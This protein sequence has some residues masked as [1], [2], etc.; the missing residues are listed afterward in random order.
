[1]VATDR[2]V[3]AGCMTPTEILAA[4]H[5]GAHA[6]KIFPANAVTPTYLR[7]LRGP[8]PDLKAIP[9][10][11]IT[12]GD[13]VARLDAGALA[14]GIGGHLSRPVHTDIDHDD[15]VTATRAALQMTP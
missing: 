13:T 15:L 8:F 2:T 11:G 12:P 3:I 5:A 6:T 10:G 9:T 1:M 7:A 14:V 4:Q